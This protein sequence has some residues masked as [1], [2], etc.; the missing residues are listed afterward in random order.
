MQP[1]N[2]P[3]PMMLLLSVTLVRRVHLANAA[4]ML[5][6]LSG[7]VTLVKLVPENAWSPMLVMLLGMM[8]YYHIVPTLAILAL[9]VFI[10]LAIAAALSVGLWLRS[11]RRLPPRAAVAAALLVPLFVWAGAVK[12][13]SPSW[14]A[15]VFFDVGQGDSALMRSGCTSNAHCV[16]MSSQSDHGSG[17]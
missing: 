12:A 10:L 3:V 17:A 11:G 4:P 5:V 2:S 8:M 6:T 13:G 1:E 9:P 7:I 14:P 15:V 16:A